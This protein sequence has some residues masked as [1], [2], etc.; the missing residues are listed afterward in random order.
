M[1]Q[2]LYCK[3]EDG[4]FRDVDGN[5]S[6][7]SGHVTWADFNTASSTSKYFWDPSDSG[8][9]I[10]CQFASKNLKGDA[11]DSFGSLVMTDASTIVNGAGSTYT[12]DLKV[13]TKQSIQALYNAGYVP[14]MPW[15]ARISPFWDSAW[16]LNPVTDEDIPGFGTD[17][18]G[19]LAF[20]TQT[21][22]Y[23]DLDGIST[24][25]EW[26]RANYRVPD[27]S[28]S[29]ATSNAETFKYGMTYRSTSGI[30]VANVASR[31]MQKEALHHAQCAYF[32]SIVV[33]QWADLMICKTRWLSIYHQG[34][35]NPAMNFGLVFETILA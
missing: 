19:T 35:I 2:I 7:L 6:M 9:I 23:F 1:G 30:V 12:A 24:D 27:G 16:L 11:S 22:G 3:L 21:A 33:V 14:F 4:V 31:M 32:V 10:D 25:Y 29:G 34:M 18:D 5:A 26:A 20:S 8:E 13:P 17:V 28:G 15:R